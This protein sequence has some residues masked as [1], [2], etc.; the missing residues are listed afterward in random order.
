MKVLIYDNK[1]KDIQCECLNEL[2]AELKLNNIDFELLNL[3]T[4]RDQIKA[5]AL[6][7]IGG[8]GTIL[9]LV[10]FAC[11]NNIPIIGINAGRLGF[12]AEF[13][14]SE[15][16]DAVK[17]LVNNDLHSDVR[18]TIKVSFKNQTYYALNDVFLRTYSH[19]AGNMTANIAVDIDDNRMTKFKG[20]GVIVSTPTGSTAYSFSLGGPLFETGLKALMILPIAA[21]SFNQR[22]IIYSSTSVAKFTSIGSFDNVGIYVDG[23][24]IGKLSPSE[25]FES[26]YSDK[27]VTFLRKAGFN[28]FKRICEKL[29]FIGGSDDE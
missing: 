1:E 8:D 29:N 18:S 20:D 14:K 5:D 25:Y 7:V 4:I 22:P 23:K 15:I 11:I 27:P 21:H 2:K 6:F 24:F 16:K 26:S 10:E 3:E 28:F 19:T 9:Q 17:L 13:E 12:L